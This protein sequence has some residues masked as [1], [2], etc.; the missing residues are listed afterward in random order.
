MCKLADAFM[1]PAG[2]EI[3]GIIQLFPFFRLA[4]PSRFNPGG[5]ICLPFN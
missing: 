3:R 1:H 5:I 2:K 4:I